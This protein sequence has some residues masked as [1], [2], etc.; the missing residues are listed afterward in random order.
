MKVGIITYHASHNIGSMLQAYAL[1]SYLEKVL[2]VDVEIIDYSSRAQ[3]DMYAI[4]PKV[5]NYKI[6]IKNI[7]SFLFYRQFKRRYDQFCWFSATFLKKSKHRL[8]SSRDFKGS[9][10]IL[11]CGS[12]QIW[13]VN[14]VDFTTFYMGDFGHASLLVSYAASLGGQNFLNGKNSSEYQA[15]INKFDMVSVRERNGKYWLDE[16][17]NKDV[18]LVPDPTLLVDEYFWYQL[19]CYNDQDLPY[20][21][22]IFFY[23]VPFSKKTYGILKKISRKLNKKI[24]MIDFKSYIYNFCW[25]RGFALHDCTSPDS[26]LKLIK[27]ASLVITTSYHGTIFSTVFK[28]KFWTITFKETN[29][30]D[31]R[32][33][34]LLE[35]LGLSDRLI[36]MEDHES[37]D[38]LSEV[39]YSLYDSNIKT[40]KEKGVDFLRRAVKMA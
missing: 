23:G 15:L 34:F 39:D 3:A 25:A 9:Y 36:Y 8:S 19:S 40:L 10:D 21:D 1:Q 6:L 5:G 32:V 7:L 30:D 4:F 18:E 26:F 33:A 16:V 38:L 17:C 22:Y 29:P 13:N 37:Y 2:H 24:V 31:D 14:C 27:N 35:Q 20:D 28:K 11:I 12:D